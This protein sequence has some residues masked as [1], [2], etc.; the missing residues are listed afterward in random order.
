MPYPRLFIDEYLED[1]LMHYLF[2]E[3]GQGLVEY[4]LLLLLVA[5]AVLITLTLLGTQLGNLFSQIAACLTDL[6]DLCR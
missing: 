2:F 4:A 1:I 3:E 6:G 5:L